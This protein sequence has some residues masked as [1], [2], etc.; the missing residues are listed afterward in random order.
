MGGSV[1]AQHRDEAA[2]MEACAD[3]DVAAVQA[4]I[5]AKRT[6]VDC[7]DDEGSTP[8]HVAAFCGHVE[9][10]RLLL[11]ASMA[12]LEARGQLDGTPLHVAA[13]AKRVEV[14]RMLLAAGAAVDASDESGLRPLHRAAAAGSP[15]TVRALLEARAAVDATTADAHTP[16]HVAAMH[17]RD[18]CDAVLELLL[19]AGADARAQNAAGE[20][21]AALARRAGA[22][23]QAAT[24]ARH[25]VR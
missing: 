2:L 23:A 17:R 14:V 8:L 5:A 6:D 22:E 18:G 1:S 21:P 7:F 25:E 9:V 24:L 16:L 10:V 11:D 20:T 15:A 13:T 19:A 3:G 12:S 4:I